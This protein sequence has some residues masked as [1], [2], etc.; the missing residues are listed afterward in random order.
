MKVR[1]SPPAKLNLFLEIPAKRN[2][3]YHEIDTVMTAI[4]L[5]DELTVESIPEPVI[6]LSASWL[7]SFEDVAGE[8]G[9]EP[10]GEAA[11]QLLG[12]PTDDRN[13]VVRALEAFRRQFA[14]E[15]GFRVQ[16]KKRIPA[17]AGMGGAS[18][19]AAHAISCAAAIHGKADEHAV[20][21]ELA[22]SIGSDVPFFLPLA[23]DAL[24]EPAVWACH[25]SGRGEIL[26]PV[27]MRTDL[28]FVVGYPCASLPTIDVY[29][30]LRVPQQPMT[31]TGLIAALDH[32]Q[33]DGL[34]TTMMNRLSEP[35]LEILPELSEL[36]ESLWQSGLQPCQLTGSGSAC[37][38]IARDAEH[39]QQAFEQLR[40]IH[41]APT[42][43]R[44][45]RSV[46]AAASIEFDPS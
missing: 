3:G 14:I 33:V 38:G 19:D 7:P 35:A 18:S 43:W 32:G 11:Q 17:G 29:R 22:A 4:D 30:R 25:A 9:L 36:L 31:S 5:R 34:S 26:R 10:N 20:L 12:I 16:L 37:F 27:N 6:E 21:H 8:L 15:G 24:P 46:S 41:S 39:A 2:D 40:A 44:A 42:L 1:T 45:T 13:L 23:A 28:H